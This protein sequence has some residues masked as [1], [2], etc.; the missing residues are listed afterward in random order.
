MEFTNTETKRPF[1]PAAA[2]TV[3][4]PVAKS[5]KPSHRRATGGDSPVSTAHDDDTA[6]DLELF[7]AGSKPASSM[8]NPVSR[9]K[10]SEFFYSRTSSP[11]YHSSSSAATST[12]GHSGSSTSASS[13]VTEKLLY[14]YGLQEFGRH[15]SASHDDE[16]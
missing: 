10:V 1:V 6:I 7:S 3:T 11:N 13:D 15:F 2:S 5:A 8:R 14:E 16:F 9:V 4:K 12:D